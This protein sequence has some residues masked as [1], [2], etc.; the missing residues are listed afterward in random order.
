MP[1]K[2]YVGDTRDLDVQK[3]LSDQSL[4]PAENDPAWL[5][6]DKTVCDILDAK[7]GRRLVKIRG[8][9]AGATTL[10]VTT[11]IAGID[12]PVVINITV[13]A[14]PAL[15]A[16]IPVIREDSRYWPVTIP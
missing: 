9:K 14:V 8:L 15:G 4:A 13:A 1:I 5:V 12:T 16:A 11:K 3:L 6:A 7:P 2:L 10:T